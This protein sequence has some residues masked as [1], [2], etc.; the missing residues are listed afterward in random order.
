MFLTKA[1][2]IDLSGEKLLGLVDGAQAIVLTLLVIELPALI[3]EAMEHVGEAST[4]AFVVVTD[5]VGYLFAALIIFDIWG[6]QK[7][8]FE[9]TKPSNIQSLI[10]VATLWLSTLVPAFFFLT[11]KF[12]Q[13]GFIES[14]SL[15]AGANFNEIVVFRSFL[16][17]TIWLIYFLLYA[18]VTNH[19]EIKKQNEISFVREL[20]RLRIVALAVIF[21]ASLLA[22]LVF[23]IAYALVPFVLFVPV[24]FV[25]PKVSRFIGS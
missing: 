23:G 2:G 8:I 20:A 3:I 11:E 12:A 25:S 21:L 17:A 14:H 6:L 4:L 19:A 22:S 24:L 18:Y 1:K 13:D 7:T 9:A 5:L 15:S 16:L 10:C